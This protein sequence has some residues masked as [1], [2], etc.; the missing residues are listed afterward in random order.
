MAQNVRFDDLRIS[1]TNLIEKTSVRKQNLKEQYYF[2]C[3]CIKCNRKEEINFPGVDQNVA[4]YEMELAKEG[5]LMCHA[6]RNCIV[7]PKT[8]GKYRLIQPWTFNLILR[9]FHINGD[10]YILYPL[11]TSSNLRMT[12]L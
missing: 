12:Y 7:I 9:I 3:N 11:Q 5:S 1:Y 4:L 6:C 10:V 8:S 2:D